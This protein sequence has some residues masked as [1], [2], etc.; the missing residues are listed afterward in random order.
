M[1]E[2]SVVWA[3]GAV[4]RRGI[5]GLVMRLE[6]A[7]RYSEV[8]EFDAET[9]ELVVYP[10]GP[11]HQAWVQGQFGFLADVLVVLFRDGLG[12]WLKIGAVC[13]PLNGSS[14]VRWSRSG[15]VSRF[16]LSS[17]STLI[18]ELDYEPGP[19]LY[20]DDTISACVEAEDFDFGLFIH[21]VW[22]DEG[23]RARIY[24]APGSVP[25]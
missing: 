17:G 20:P 11:E 19:G 21:N 15:A 24:A 18:A 10:R 22:R 23:R 16:S 1:D 2:G 12:L 9:G 13:L 4:E 14:A 25:G 6:S 7:H 8:A 3:P 5:E